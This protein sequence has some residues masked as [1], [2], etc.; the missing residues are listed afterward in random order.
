MFDLPIGKAIIAVK[1]EYQCTGRCTEE[2]YKCPT[3]NCCDE[4]DLRDSQYESLESEGEY[5]MACSNWDRKDGIYVHYK[6]VDYP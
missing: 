6:I 1:R 3:P 4:C 5:C 2:D